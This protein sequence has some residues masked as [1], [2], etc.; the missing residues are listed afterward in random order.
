MAIRCLYFKNRQTMKK[1]QIIIDVYHFFSK[2]VSN[3]IKNL[4]S[5]DKVG[6]PHQKVGI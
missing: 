6:V 4:F 1:A 2:E 5:Y 3:P